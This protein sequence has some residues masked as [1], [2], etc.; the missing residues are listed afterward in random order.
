MKS[1]SEAATYIR[2]RI[3]T[4]LND[5]EYLSS[6]FH[7]MFPYLK[8]ELSD[9]SARRTATYSRVTEERHYIYFSKET[10]VQRL[11][12][13]LWEKAGVKAV[14]LRKSGKVWI[15]PALTYDWTL[16]QQNN[17]GEA[18]TKQLLY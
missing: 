4:E 1:I 11:I 16:E 14:V 13:D 8:L 2:R 15:E 9:N 17:E 18:I 3:M 10:T 5:L 7:L 6:N 12:S